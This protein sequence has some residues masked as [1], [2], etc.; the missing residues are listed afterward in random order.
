MPKA[1]KYFL[2]FIITQNNEVKYEFKLSKFII[3]IIGIVFSAIF[4]VLFYYLLERF[5]INQV[6]KKIIFIYLSLGALCSM[7]SQ[8]IYLDKNEDDLTGLL[9]PFASYKFVFISPIYLFKY[10]LKISEKED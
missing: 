8:N 4:I 6:L 1:I 2:F 5:N 10:C 3:N 7:P 9:I